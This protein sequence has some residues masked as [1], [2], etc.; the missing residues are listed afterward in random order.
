MSARR[1]ITCVGPRVYNKMDF[2]D[3]VCN[4]SLVSRGC[5][6]IIA[7]M[8]KLLFTKIFAWLEIFILGIFS[9]S[10]CKSTDRL[11]IVWGKKNPYCPTQHVFH[12]YCRDFIF[13]TMYKFQLDR[14]SLFGRFLLAFAKCVPRCL[15]VLEPIC[16]SGSF[17]AVKQ[18]NFS[19]G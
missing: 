8:N 13:C 2:I 12:V 14:D 16:F 10:K 3:Q 17:L 9:L 15:N 6:P 11:A 19:R 5:A 7:V 4:F 1:D 18:F